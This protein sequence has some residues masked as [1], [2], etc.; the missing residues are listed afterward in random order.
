MRLMLAALLAL[1]TSGC[2][3][4]APLPKQI[5][6]DQY[7]GLSKLPDGTTRLNVLAQVTASAAY[8]GDTAAVKRFLKDFRGDPRH[9]D[10]AAKCATQLADKDMAGAEA[11]SGS[12][13][14]PDRRAEA[15]GKLHPKP[16]GSAKQD[17][18]AASP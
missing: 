8:D 15:L 13:E 12:I 3:F 2:A 17:A 4:F 10:L 1:T 5:W 7:H 6:L 14:D 9:D 11:V 16:A 18:A